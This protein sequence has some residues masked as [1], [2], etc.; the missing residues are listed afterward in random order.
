[1]DFHVY[2]APGWQRSGLGLLLA[3]FNVTALAQGDSKLGSGAVV[4]TAT[5]TPE[6]AEETLSAVTVIDSQEIARRQVLSLEELFQGEAGIQI[7]NNGGL[8]KVS[9]VYLRGTEAEEVLVLVDG[10]RMGSVSL[11]TTAFQYLPVDQIDHVE[12]VR[13]PRSSMYGS[14]AIGGVIQIFTRRPA[15]GFRSEAN[16]ATGSHSTQSYAGALSGQA[17]R[18]GYSV[19]A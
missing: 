2:R 17:E 9:S 13:G 4:I 3:G 7:N 18:L 11:G 14:E 8:G 6:L 15:D 12:I 19:S 5:R 16:A 1:M 10:I